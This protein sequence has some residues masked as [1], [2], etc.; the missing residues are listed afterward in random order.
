M[1]NNLGGWA[2]YFKERETKQEG[3][4]VNGAAQIKSLGKTLVIAT[5]SNKYLREQ[6]HQIKAVVDTAKWDNR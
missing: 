4:L 2:N 5:K 3:E 6:S 1:S